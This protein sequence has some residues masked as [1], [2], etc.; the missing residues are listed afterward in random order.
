MD[1]LEERGPAYLGEKKNRLERRPARL[2]KQPDLKY[3]RSD[4]HLSLYAILP[5]YG[6][7]FRE[8][9]D[10]KAKRAKGTIGASHGRVPRTGLLHP[11]ASSILKLMA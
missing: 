6:D 1:L 7:G 10:A 8:R 4:S 9:G 2:G 5:R 3:R 11:Y